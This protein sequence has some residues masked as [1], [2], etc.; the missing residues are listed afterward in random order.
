MAKL[1]VLL[2][3]LR[4][5]A[6]VTDTPGD[7]ALYGLDKPVLS[8]EWKVSE[9]AVS[10]ADAGTTKTLQVGGPGPGKPGSRF[11]RLSGL[12]TV[13]TLG[14][15]A[16]EILGAELREH[17]VLTLKLNRIAGLTLRRPDGSAHY[18]R[19][20]RAFAVND[21]WQAEGAIG[22][23]GFDPKRL[24]PLLSTVATL[25]TNRF[26]QYQGAIPR[27]YGLET[28]VLAVEV[29]FGPVR[30]PA[31]LRISRRAP[32]GKARYAT[33]EKGRSGAVF[34]LPKEFW[35]PYLGEEKAAEKPAEKPAEK[36]LP[37]KVFAPLIAPASG[38]CSPARCRAGYNRSTRSKRPRSAWSR[39][40]LRIVKYPHPALRFESSPVTRIDDELRGQVREMFDLMYENRGIGLAA[41]QVGLPYRFFVLNLSADP[42]KP[43]E[44]QVFINPEIVKRH[45]SIE[46][47][48]GCLSFPGLYGDVQR[49]KRVRVRAYDLNGE[50]HEYDAEDL[51][52]RAVQHETDHLAGRLYI[53]L[54]APNTL[55]AAQ[56]KIRE[57]EIQY[58]QA[59]TAGEIPS[60]DEIDPRQLKELAGQ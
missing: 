20:P 27:E 18:R 24:G 7:P 45:S 17:K 14:P 6:L 15:E 36:A 13:F 42:E 11:A 40:V 33:V 22:L 31:I 47:E 10:T 60:D 32:G 49:A 52:S 4:A 55:S 44:E 48:E 59:Q 26:V 34:L 35:E 56:P 51:F 39:L 41:N 3:R 2:A 25:T 46:A 5:E 8:V 30:A 28:P 54:F 38:A 53:D 23:K 58:R 29:D 9:G 21:D 19:E 43:E 37:E 16:V 1:A 57:L 50:E 12:R